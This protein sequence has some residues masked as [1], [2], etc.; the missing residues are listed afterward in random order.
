MKIDDFKTVEKLI[1]IRNNIC[2]A[3]DSVPKY[4]ETQE[5]GGDVGMDLTKSGYNS[6]LV[7][8]SDGSGTRVDL[9]GCY[10]GVE[11]G[12]AALAVLRVKLEEVELQLTLHG[13]DL[14]LEV[15]EALGE[16]E[17]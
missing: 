3:I 15:E 7:T 12:V 6:A 13:V 9:R 2:C 8:H 11:M 5:K 1:H 10:V 14:E 4:I 17:E 16:S